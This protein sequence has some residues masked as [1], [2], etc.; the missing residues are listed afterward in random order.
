[1]NNPKT[2]YES[3]RDRPG[4]FIGGLY[5]TAVSNLLNQL[6]I[7]VLNHV[8]CKRIEVFIFRNNIICVQFELSNLDDE[9]RLKSFFT[10]KEIF[11]KSW[12][13]GKA[14]AIA[15]SEHFSVSALGEMREY[16]N[17]HRMIKKHKLESDNERIVNIEFKLA[18]KHLKEILPDKKF[19]PE[20]LFVLSACHPDLKIIYTDKTISPF[21]RNIYRFPKGL[22]DLMIY[23]SQHEST[24]N[25][26]IHQF[27][28]KS[29]LI[30]AD[31]VFCYSSSYYPFRWSAMNNEYTQSHGSH[32]DGVIEGCLA[33]IR[34]EAK[35]TKQ[36]LPS[37]YNKYFPGRIAV[38]ISAYSD[39]AEY[40]GAV[41]YR[42]VK[43]DFIPVISAAVQKYLESV[44]KDNPQGI[45]EFIDW[46]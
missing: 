1:M 34:S 37:W 18:E 23:M 10:K 46:I 16:S 45:Q 28:F 39:D 17:N 4:M 8:K 26:H 27:Q 44:K 3:I 21:T 2:I 36:K 43:K 31:I 15:L 38:A 12:S 20:Y 33:Y 40:E 22:K 30:S 35:R 24:N 13:L 41:R 32:V 7:D 19:L 11:A 9:K 6:L 42:V 5:R 14:S 25:R 29:E